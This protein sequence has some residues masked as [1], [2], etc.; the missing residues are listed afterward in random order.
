M[1]NLLKLSISIILLGLMSC[2]Q[3]V[4]FK[5]PTPAV[6]QCQATCAQHFESCKAQ[7]RNSCRICSTKSKT[8]TEKRYERYGDQQMLQGKAINRELDSYRDPLQCLKVSCNCVADLDA[9]NQGCTG[10]VR[11]QL[12]SNPLPDCV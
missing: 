7:C 10:I 4:F 2:S 3:H 5:R 11:K 9:C 6:A 8:S 1:N 12:L